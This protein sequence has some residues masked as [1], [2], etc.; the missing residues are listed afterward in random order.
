LR[1]LAVRTFWSHIARANEFILIPRAIHAH[2][3]FTVLAIDAVKI[4]IT[5]TTG[6]VEK[7]GKIVISLALTEPIICN[8][9]HAYCGVTVL[10]TNANPNQITM[11]SCHVEWTREEYTAVKNGLFTM[12]FLLTLDL[13]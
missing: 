8:D 11:S 1:L 9:P 6:V 4:T 7:S 13:F 10:F 12:I 5:P 2:L 3:V